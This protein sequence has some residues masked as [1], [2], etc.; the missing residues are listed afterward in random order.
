MNRT[1]EALHR[2]MAQNRK[3]RALDT[4]EKQLLKAKSRGFK[5]T[6]IPLPDLETLL[7]LAKEQHV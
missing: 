4:M 2:W 5:K 6:Q 1:N 7:E 3:R